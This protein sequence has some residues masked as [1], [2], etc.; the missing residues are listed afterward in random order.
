[1]TAMRRHISMAHAALAAFVD[2]FNGA[3]RMLRAAR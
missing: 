2:T 1:M 3:A